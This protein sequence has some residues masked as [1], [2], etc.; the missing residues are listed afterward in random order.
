MNRR[1]IIVPLVVAL[2]G[3]AGIW[4]LQNL[5]ATPQRVWVGFRG[6]ARDDPWFAAK[7]L[8]A[9]MELRV[10]RAKSIP[11][12]NRL[13]ADGTLVLP[14]RLASV[15]RDAQLRLLA[16]VEGGGHLVVEGENPGQP[17]PLLDAL[18]I[19]RKALGAR[20]RAAAKADA[21]PSKKS[22]AARRR[23]PRYA[24]ATLP[25]APAPMRVEV[26]LWRTLEAKDARFALAEAEATWLVHLERGAGRVTAITDLSFANN[27]SLRRRDHAEFL[28]QLVRLAP[29]RASVTFFHSPKKLSVLDWLREHAWAV[30]AAGAVLLAA[31]LWRIVP[32]FGPVAPDPEPARRRLL[33]HLR[34]SGRF[35]WSSGGAQALAEAAREAA[36]RRVARAHPDFAALGAA[37]REARLAAQFGL[38]PEGVRRVLHPPTDASP[39]GLV[40]ATR[41]YQAI[42]EQL[43]QTRGT[44]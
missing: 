8:L 5:E 20:T 26:G 33:D 13:P 11:E 24:T 34:A 39:A 10:G 44:R 30:L 35:Q 14:R 28:W 16:W 17:D 15:D 7:R 43:S 36:L 37:E 25:G 38:S 21:E 9:R 2:A 29:Q 42:H 1:A 4:I 6:E 23:V 40:A 32:R 19:G 22:D 41:V 18:G 3:A 31:W 12:L 27:Q